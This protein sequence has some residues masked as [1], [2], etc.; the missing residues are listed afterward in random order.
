MEFI[1]AVL[2]MTL[3]FSTPHRVWTILANLSGVCAA[4]FALSA[5]PLSWLPIITR[6]RA[7]RAVRREGESLASF[8]RIDTAGYKLR[9]VAEYRAVVMITTCIAILAVDFPSVFPRSHAK[10][11][12][13]GFSLMD[14]GTGCVVCSSAVC[15]RAARGIK[16]DR[17]TCTTFRRIV[18]LWPIL[19]LGCVRLVALWGIDYHVPTSEYGVHWNFFFTI[20]VVAMTSSAA[21]L[22][23]SACA[24]SGLLVL[25][26]YQLFLSSAGGAEY[27][28]TAPRVGMFSANREGILGCAG[29]LGIHWLSVSLGSLISSSTKP[30]HLITW[31]VLMLAFC[32][33]G[34]AL[35]L[36]TIGMPPSHRMCN[37]TYSVFI[38]GI[39]ALVLGSL[40]VLDLYWPWQRQPLPSIYGGVQDS[41]LATFLLAN[42]LTGAINVTMQPLLMPPWAGHLVI[43]VYSIAWSLPFSILRSRGIA[44]KFW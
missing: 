42:L 10:T 4:L 3:G 44:L 30:P 41:L 12:E 8:S 1:L 27:I 15:S 17:S 14:L 7:M 28:L 24:I 36:D 40:A 34:T 2:P 21:D 11:E 39:N 5:E 29:H 16:Q 6:M 32:G 18:G 26:I 23:P 9:F 20:A 43:S 19:L 13:Y 33:I 38:V 25:S 37:L 22:G 35:L 31:R